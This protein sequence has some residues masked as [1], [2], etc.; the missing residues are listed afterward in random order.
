MRDGGVADSPRSLGLRDDEFAEIDH[1]F[2]HFPEELNGLRE[3]FD[4]IHR[5]VK[6]NET[7][8]MDALYEK[9]TAMFQ[10]DNELN[11]KVGVFLRNLAPGLRKPGIEQ[12][13]RLNYLLNKFNI[14]DFDIF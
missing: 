12:K 10:D 8:C 4:D 13:Y 3:D 1:F 7:P 6:N 11:I 2:A 9:L 14:P 5:R